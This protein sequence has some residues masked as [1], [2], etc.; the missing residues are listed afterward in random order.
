[1]ILKLFLMSF[2]MILFKRNVFHA[3]YQIAS[4]DG[5]L[6]LQKGLV[7]FV[8][9][10][11]VCNTARLGLYQIASENG[12]NK[13]RDGSVSTVR[14]LLCAIT[15]GGIGGLLCSPFSWWV[16]PV[17]VAHLNTK[18]NY[19]CYFSFQVKTHLQ[20]KANSAIAVGHQHGHLGMFD[21]FRTFY[22]QGGVFGLWRGWQ[23]MVPRIAAASASQLLT[24]EKSHGPRL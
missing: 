3:S 10:Q 1:M 5:I 13:N 11:F 12:L 17:K 7:P 6:A 8:C 2:L 20:S 14:T 9:Y 16:I 21:A 23:S 4:K 22:Y 18:K 15:T 19:E 24:F